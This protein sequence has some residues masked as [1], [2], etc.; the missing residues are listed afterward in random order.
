M[1]LYQ[2]F[3]CWLIVNELVVVVVILRAADR[4]G[5]AAPSTES[6]AMRP[7]R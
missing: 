4:K 6:R 1:T 2:L 3:M 7:V 5:S